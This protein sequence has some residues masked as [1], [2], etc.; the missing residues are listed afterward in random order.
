MKLIREEI[1]DIEVLTENVDGKKNMF[2]EGI[3]M[4]SVPNKNGRVYPMETLVNEVN[5]YIKEKVSTKRSYG[6]LGHPKGPQINLDRISHIVE[7]LKPDGKNIIGKAKL[8]ETPMGNIAKGI[9]ESGGQLGMSSRGLGSLKKLDDGLL[10]VQDDFKLITAADIVAD[11]SA[12]DAFVNGIMENVEWVFKNGEWVAEAAE[13]IQ[14]ALKKM[15]RRQIEESK[16]R[17]FEHF[18]NEISKTK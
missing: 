17:V 10:E 13:P 8:T 7:S 18:L 16:I 3:F 11:P 1:H 2:L 6:E 5:R 9:I 15:S 14:K 12:P 4:Q